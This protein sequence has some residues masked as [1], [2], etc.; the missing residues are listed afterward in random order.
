M[1]RLYP[2]SNVV[3]RWKLCLVKLGLARRDNQLLEALMASEVR[4]AG[5]TSNTNFARLLYLLD[6]V[7]LPSLI[8]IVVEQFTDGCVAGTLIDLLFVYIGETM[9]GCLFPVGTCRNGE[10]VLSFVFV[11]VVLSCKDGYAL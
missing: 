1:V 8:V 3:S 7:V 5:A 6:G 10:F 11:L 2:G 9:T 4:L